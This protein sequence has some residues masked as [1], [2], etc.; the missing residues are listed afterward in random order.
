MCRG[1]DGRLV[2]CIGPVFDADSG[3]DE[4]VFSVCDVADRVDVGI[5]AAQSS[6]DQHAIIDGQAGLLG[7]CG[8]RC[9]ADTY[10]DSIGRDDGPVG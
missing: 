6:R 5:A 1:R 8:V 10:H 2:E 3:S 9:G 7:Q 4:R